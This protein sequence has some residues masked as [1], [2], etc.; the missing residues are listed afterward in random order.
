MKYKFLVHDYDG[1]SHY[2]VSDYDSDKE[3]RRFGFGFCDDVNYVES[4]T[5]TRLLTDDP[6][7]E[8]VYVADVM[9]GDDD[10]LD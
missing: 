3:A 6:E 9:Y 8:D 7:G 5:I 4:V 1:F 2:F 10:E